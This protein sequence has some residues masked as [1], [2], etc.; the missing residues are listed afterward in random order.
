MTTAAPSEEYS[1]FD[2][3]LSGF[4]DEVEKRGVLYIDPHKYQYL[5]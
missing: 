2:L 4:G 3:D 1:R 5:S